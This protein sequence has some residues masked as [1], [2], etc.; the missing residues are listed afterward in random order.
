MK[1]TEALNLKQE[2]EALLRL[3]RMGVHDTKVFVLSAS[4][5]PLKRH[6]GNGF[7]SWKY[8]YVYVA[9]IP[10]ERCYV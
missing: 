5:L 6:T 1:G 4:F 3:S 10:R 9:H 2:K 8:C 7:L